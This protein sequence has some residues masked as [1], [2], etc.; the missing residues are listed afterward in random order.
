MKSSSWKILLKS[1][2]KKRIDAAVF[3]WQW[4]L[5][6]IG[7]LL[8]DTYNKRFNDIILLEF[9]ICQCSNN[10]WKC[11]VVHERSCSKVFKKRIDAAVFR[12]H[13]I[14]TSR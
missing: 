4:L 5:N 13:S 12:G 11:K 10:A 14:I 1:F 8:F 7:I 3:I 9:V 2:F 6:T